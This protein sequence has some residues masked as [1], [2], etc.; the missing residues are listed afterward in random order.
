VRFLFSVYTPFSCDSTDLQ[1]CKQ[2]PEPNL[3]KLAEDHA[4]GKVLGDL[5]DNEDAESSGDDDKE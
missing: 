1:V 2:K 4:L 3:I 5:D